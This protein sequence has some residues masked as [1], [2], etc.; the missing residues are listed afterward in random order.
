[1]SYLVECIEKYM[2]AEGCTKGNRRRPLIIPDTSFVVKGCKYDNYEDISWDLLGDNLSYTD[3]LKDEYEI[4]N[5]TYINGYEKE[6]SDDVYESLINY[7]KHVKEFL[8]E[9][10]DEIEAVEKYED[11]LDKAIE[12]S[13]EEENFVSLTDMGILASAMELY[14]RRVVLLSDDDDIV[15]P[16]NELRNEGYNSY[17]S[18]F[19]N[20]VAMRNQDICDFLEVMEKKRRFW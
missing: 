7:G 3:G 4:H 18:G 11:V 2:D 6:I 9:D 1:M 14:P 15:L 16:A 10:F 8:N 13:F 20:I 19:S 12:E 17:N 5:N